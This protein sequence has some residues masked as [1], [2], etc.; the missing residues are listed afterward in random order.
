MRWLE[1]I[2]KIVAL[3]VLGLGL[4]QARR[5]ASD[6]IKNIGQFGNDTAGK[7]V[8]ARRCEFNFY[9]AFMAVVV[10]CT[11]LFELVGRELFIALLVAILTSLGIKLSLDSRQK[12]G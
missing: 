6:F 2:T 9:L 4:W 5:L 11:G 7:R 3:G 10:V 1:A 8:A 12:L